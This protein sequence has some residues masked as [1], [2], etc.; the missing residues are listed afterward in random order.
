MMVSVSLPLSIRRLS[1]ALK[2][3]SLV[4]AMEGVLLVMWPASG[5]HPDTQGEQGPPYCVLA[6]LKGKISALV[7][8]SKVGF[9]E[10]IKAFW[11][12]LCFRKMQSYFLILESSYISITGE[13]ESNIWKGTLKKIYSHSLKNQA[14]KTIFPSPITQAVSWGRFSVSPKEGCGEGKHPRKSAYGVRSPM[15][16]RSKV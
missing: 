7:P 15:R 2:D 14:D 13:T 16:L 3:N 9:W 1:W 5:F 8:E 4:S 11:L 10:I 12:I 6:T